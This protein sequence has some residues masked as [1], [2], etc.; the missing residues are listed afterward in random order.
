MDNV[1]SRRILSLLDYYV[2]CSMESGIFKI[3]SFTYFDEI[4]LAQ[5]D[6]IK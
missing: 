6:D 5:R 4:W 2:A 3:L 1:I